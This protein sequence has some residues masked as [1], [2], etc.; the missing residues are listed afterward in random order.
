M[1]TCLRRRLR[2]CRHA[3][4]AGVRQ[5]LPAPYHNREPHSVGDSGETM[6]IRSPIPR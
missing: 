4:A 5:A 6:Q 2:T 1:K 3:C